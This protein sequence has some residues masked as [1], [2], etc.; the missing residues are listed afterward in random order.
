TMTIRTATGNG[1]MPA[2][3]DRGRVGRHIDRF[4]VYIVCLVHLTA[5]DG[6]HSNKSEQE[7]AHQHSCPDTYPLQYFS[8]RYSQQCHSPAST[9]ESNSIFLLADKVTGGRHTHQL[10]NPAELRCL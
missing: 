8:H 6:V 7:Q 9:G 1:D 5:A 4:Y 2:Q 10:S 3:F